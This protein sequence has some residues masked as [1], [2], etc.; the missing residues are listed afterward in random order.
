MRLD[1]KVRLEGRLIKNKDGKEI[2]EDE[3]IVFRPADNAVPRLLRGYRSICEALGAS[4]DQLAGIDGLIDRVDAWRAAHPDR[5]KVPDVEP[6]E[7]QLG[8]PSLDRRASV[9]DGIVELRK[10][11]DSL[12]Y[13]P[14]EG[15]GLYL[16]RAAEA[17]NDIAQAIGLKGKAPGQ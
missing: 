3:F 14:P 10:A 17:L 11:L 2:P 13:A 5:C 1:G 8:G 9:E 4:A 16:G 15:Q 12:D 6:G 7:I